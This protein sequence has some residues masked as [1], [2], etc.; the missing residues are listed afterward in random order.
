MILE[1]STSGPMLFILIK[2]G[3]KMQKIGNYR[4]TCFLTSS[5]FNYYVLSEKVSLIEILC[6]NPSF[7]KK[8]QLEL[9][10]HTF[11][12]KSIHLVFISMHIQIDKTLA[13]I[14]PKTTTF[15]NAQSC[16]KVL[17]ILTSVTET[18]LTKWLHSLPYSF[19][20]L[21]FFWQK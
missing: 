4:H 15:K 2:T 7:F 20:L 12:F 8:Y 21:D 14:F 16:M 13:T 17:H 11:L 19:L 6:K 10:L 9:N 5:S 1:Q 3:A 18:F